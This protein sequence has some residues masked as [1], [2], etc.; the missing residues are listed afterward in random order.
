[1]AIFVDLRIS[2]R[3]RDLAEPIAASVYF[4]PEAQEAYAALG[5]DNYAISYFSSRGACL[6]RPSGEVVTAAFGVFNPAIVIPSVEQ[7]WAKT[8]P[9]SLLAA[10]EKGATAALHRMLADID[11]SPAVEILRPAM[12]SVAFAGRALFS[13][14][15]SLPFPSDPIGRLWRVC[16]Y[17]RERRGDNH[18]AAWIAAGCDPVEIGLLTELY[19][20]RELSSYI[21][22][23][24]WSQQDIDAGIERLVEKGYVEDRAFTEVGREYRRGIEAATD[25]M[26]AD[27]VEALGDNA[28]ELC[29][30]LE[31][32][33]AAV[34]DAKG[35]PANPAEFM[36]QP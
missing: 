36:N 18:I 24:G 13:G 28:G 26:D 21:H 32:W 10:R 5:L 7:A 11:T 25:A 3:L 31:P 6:G 16:D 2:R 33:T 8:D 14:L 9:D 30:L 27:V 20:G 1:M 35:Y 4:V 34:L 12:E 15:R 29:A 19:W 17:I 23:R 22:T